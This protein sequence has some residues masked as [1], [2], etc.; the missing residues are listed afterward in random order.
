MI[1]LF[2]MSRILVRT[3]LGNFCQTTVATYK[4]VSGFFTHP[5]YYDAV[6][7][8]FKFI[9]L[10]MDHS[11]FRQTFELVLFISTAGKRILN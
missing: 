2:H 3:Y 5:V 9:Q 8:E 11:P 10:S 7:F 6:Q 4:R 1:H